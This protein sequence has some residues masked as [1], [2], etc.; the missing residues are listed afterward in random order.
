MSEFRLDSIIE[1]IKNLDAVMKCPF[2]KTDPLRFLRYEGAY[3]HPELEL[4]VAC[5]KCRLK[6]T[7]KANQVSQGWNKP[8]KT[9]WSLNRVDRVTDY[10]IR[11][12]KE[13]GKI[14]P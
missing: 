3:S 5:L 8:K 11:E 6:L 1:T 10:E 12:V 14:N 4:N 9:V 7:F 2:C 13:G